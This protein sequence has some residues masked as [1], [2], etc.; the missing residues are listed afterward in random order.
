MP[1]EPFS[2]RLHDSGTTFRR[3]PL[4]WRGPRP[5][6][7][8]LLV[9]LA[10][11][12]VLA[13]VYLVL[14]LTPLSTVQNVTVV[15]VQGP[16]AS[17]IRHAIERAATGQSTL[18]FQEG[19]I[20][21]AVAGTRSITGV[22][23][24]TRFPHGV[25]VEVRQLLAVGAIEAGGRRVAVSSD[26]RVLPDWTPGTLPVIRGGQQRGGELVGG[27]KVAARILGGAPGP[28]LARVARIDGGYTVRLATG[29]ALLFRDAHRL[30]AKWAAAV[31]VLSDPGTRG[32]T[33]IDLRVPEQPVAGNGAPPTLPARD[34]KVGKVPVSADALATA[35]GRT[36][37]ATPA[38]GAT[39]TAAEAGGP[40]QA[41]GAAATPRAAAPSGTTPAAGTPGATPGAGPMTT[42]QSPAPSA[43]SGT[44]GGAPTTSGASGTASTT[45]T[46]STN[47]GAAATAAG[48]PAGAGAA[49]QNGGGTAPGAQP[50]P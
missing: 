38:G 44:G 14:R 43:A 35:E 12:G 49:V 25:Q 8:A 21:D 23:V 31:A 7:A 42:A 13:I 28:I 9:L 40:D 26:G 24:H 15:G 48:A 4:A 17:Q 41:P 39:P 50:A 20:R 19:A 37:A 10:V 27:A 34:A 3:T 36:A 47:S 2:A 29:P 6:R 32:A 30:E 33:W 1:P 11:A 18:G 22:E 46:E 5:G 16:K 45:P